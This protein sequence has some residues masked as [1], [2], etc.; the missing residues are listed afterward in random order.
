MRELNKIIFDVRRNT[1][2]AQHILPLNVPFKT[3]DFEFTFIVNSQEFRTSLI[4]SELL[5]PD[6]C[7]I[8]IID[9]T[10]D[11]VTINTK[12]QGNFSFFLQLFNFEKVTLSKSDFF[13]M[14]SIENS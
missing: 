1:Y 8:D 5:S 13:C 4:I 12:Y 3:Y 9:P 7:K 14:R 10:F 11:R 2:S 6:I